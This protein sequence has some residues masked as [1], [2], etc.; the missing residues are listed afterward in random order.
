MNI[1]VTGATGFVGRHLCHEL[2]DAG[3]DVIAAVRDA[4]VAQRKYPQLSMCREIPDYRQIKAFGDWMPCLEGVDSVVHLAGLAHAMGKGRRE[5]IGL[6]QQVNE[7]ATR[8]LVR[9]CVAAG[10]SQFIFASTAK[11]YGDSSPAGPYHEA[12]TPAPI[13]EYA[14]SKLAAERAILEET[15]GS[16]CRA[17]IIRP[18]MIYGPDVGGNFP[19]LVRLVKSGIPLPLGSVRNRRS[20]V[21]IWNV[22]SLVQQVLSKPV[23]HG[24]VLL[25]TDVRPVSTP[26][27]LR[28]IA[29]A[30]NGRAII[31]AMPAGFLSFAGRAFGMGDEIARLVDSME[32]DGSDTRRILEWSPPLSPEEG[33]R[34]AVTRMLA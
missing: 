8:A 10:V 29:A 1:L 25:P 5:A 21:S 32:L 6:Y 23:A 17:V 30:M 9:A 13:G 12:D 16:S 20:L 28:S 31:F 33:I 3:F 22:C 14:E 27:L 24:Q 15:A 18:P 34:R 4:T 11:V 2:A 26:E 19:R 7:T